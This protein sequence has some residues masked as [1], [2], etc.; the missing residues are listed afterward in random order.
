LRQTLCGRLDVPA[1]PL[2]VL[3]SR[4]F[5][6]QAEYD[7]GL[8]YLGLVRLVRSGWGLQDASAAGI[9]KAVTTGLGGIM[10]TPGQMNGHEAPAVSRARQRLEEMRVELRRDDP[11][12][13]ILQAVTSICVDGMWT[14]WLKRLVTKMRELP[15]DWRSLGDLKEGLHRLSEF[16]T[17]R[18]RE[19]SPIRAEAAE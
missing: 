3:F 5:I 1:E 4:G 9:W 2:S 19:V 10:I 18:W 17:T 12:G 11:G 8:A 14:A 15:G 7:S 13:A 6:S 16:G